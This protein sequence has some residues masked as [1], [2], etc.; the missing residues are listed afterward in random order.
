ME[1]TCSTKQTDLLKEELDS[2][3]TWTDDANNKSGSA[4]RGGK[5]TSMAPLS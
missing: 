4:L 2:D 1:H 3:T 5:K